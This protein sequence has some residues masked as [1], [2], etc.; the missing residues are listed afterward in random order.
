MIFDVDGWKAHAVSRVA[1]Q[2]RAHLQRM[3]HMGRFVPSTIVCLIAMV[4]N[5][6]VALALDAK[7]LTEE[8]SKNEAG[9]KQR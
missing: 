6:S 3:N 2:L 8:F 1:P 4:A 5:V 9:F 7:Q